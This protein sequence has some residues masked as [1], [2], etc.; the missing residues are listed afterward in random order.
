MQRSWIG[1]QPSG[2]GRAEQAGSRGQWV[3]PG[4]GVAVRLHRAGAP[5]NGARRCPIIPDAHGLGPQS[6]DIGLSRGADS[7]PKASQAAR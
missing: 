4:R 1:E 6:G 7:I 5:P 3:A 2:G